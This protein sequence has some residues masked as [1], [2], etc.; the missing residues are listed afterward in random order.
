MRGVGRAGWALDYHWQ[1]LWFPKIW[2]QC[3][4]HWIHG[5]L[6]TPSHFHVHFQDNHPWWKDGMLPSQCNASLHSCTCTINCIYLH[7]QDH[8][9]KMRMVFL[10]Y[11]PWESEI[12]YLSPRHLLSEIHILKLHG[13]TILFLPSETECICILTCRSSSQSKNQHTLNHQYTA[14]N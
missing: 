11:H 14:F 3:W 10:Q 1:L 2:P 9:E 12:F 7:N 4:A 6:M 13:S 8:E 5:Y